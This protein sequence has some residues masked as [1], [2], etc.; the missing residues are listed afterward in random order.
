MGG[1]GHGDR[2]SPYFVRVCVC[3]RVCAYVCLCVCMY[4]CSL[5]K[6]KSSLGSTISVFLF[7][8]LFD[9]V[10]RDQLGWKEDMD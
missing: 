2:F 4:V 3:V 9:D 7:C 1:P 6:T 8:S 10:R 5:D